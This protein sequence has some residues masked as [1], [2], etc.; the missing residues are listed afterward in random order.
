MISDFT[1]TRVHERTIRV[2]LVT[3]GIVTGTQDIRVVMDFV[4]EGATVSGEDLLMGAS[5]AMST[6]ERAKLEELATMIRTTDG[7]DRIILMQEYNTMIENW[8]DSFSKA[9]S[10]IDI[11][12]VIDTTS[13][14]ADK[15]SAMSALIDM[16]LIGDAE[17]TDEITLATKLIEDLIPETSP[18]R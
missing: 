10:L 18:N 7:A 9:K 3:G 5:G 15:K 6:F 14:T 11:Q 17:S 12:E 4:P 13:L 16:L 2:T 1:D 8:S